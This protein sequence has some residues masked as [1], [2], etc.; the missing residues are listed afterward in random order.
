MQPLSMFPIILIRSRA[1]L[2]PEHQCSMTSVASRPKCTA[3]LEIAPSKALLVPSTSLFLQGNK[4]FGFVEEKPGLFARREFKA[5]EATLGFMRVTSG[6][7]AGEKIVADGA[8]LLQ[9]MLTAKSTAPKEGPSA[10][11]TAGKAAETS[12]Q[13]A[14]PKDVEKP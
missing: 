8:L 11:A 5:E 1:Q 14:T 4:Y 2:R 13:M 9:Q 7:D 6:A 10:K 12:S 3:D